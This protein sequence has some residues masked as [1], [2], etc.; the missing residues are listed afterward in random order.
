MLSFVYNCTRREAAGISASVYEIIA[1]AARY[2][3]AAIMLLIVARAWKITIV[4]SRRAASLRRL[5]PETGV[6][7]EFLVVRGHGRAKDG[8]RYPVIR[9]G[10][11]GSSRKA[12]IRLRSSSVRRVHA[13]FELTPN[14][15][16]LRGQ[17]GAHM[18]NARGNSRRELLLG[19]GSRVTIGQV[20][21]LLILTEAVGMPAEPQDTGLFDVPGVS[22][23]PFSRMPDRRAA[24]SEQEAPAQ[25][26]T[27]PFKRPEIISVHDSAAADESATA[28]DKRPRAFAEN[29]FS[30]SA[31][32]SDASIPSAKAPTSASFAPPDDLFMDGTSG[33]LRPIADAWDDDEDT[34]DVIPWDDDWKPRPKKRAVKKHPGGDDFFGI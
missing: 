9:E 32:P 22:P 15:L 20:E 7:G 1:L 11:I 31:R 34:E 23:A 29:N 27:S 30:P 17:R 28:R 5:S 16:R 8:M 4:D 24:A 14:G 19:D 10:L 6:C 25:T 18:F 12:D 3:F 13:F 2:F 33:T 26:E 21:L